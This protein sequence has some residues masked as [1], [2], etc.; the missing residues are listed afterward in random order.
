MTPDLPIPD[1]PDLIQAAS[2]LA[3]TLDRENR[4]L[5]ALDLA[6]AAA[7]L[8]EKQR[9]AG[10]FAA[11]QARAGAAPGLTPA[12]RHAAAGLAG[13][14][15][16]LVAENRRLLERGMAAQGQVIAVIARAVR[17][18]PAVAPRYGATGA[19]AAPRS[20]APLAISARV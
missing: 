18:Q 19:A 15:R 5:A 3:A 20:P 4:M 13:R 7:L 2:D 16:D 10:A 6:G 17:T 14:L 8:P 9:A 12:V 11:A 1:G